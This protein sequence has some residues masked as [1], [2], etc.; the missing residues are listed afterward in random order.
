MQIN[1]FKTNSRTRYCIY[2]FGRDVNIQEVQISRRILKANDYF[3][4]T[5]DRE[6]VYSFSNRILSW[7]FLSSHWMGS[8]SARK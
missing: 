4:T 8:M 7:K 2:A 3:E 1:L 6:E 5:E